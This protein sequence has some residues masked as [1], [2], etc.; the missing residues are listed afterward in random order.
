MTGMEVLLSKNV[1][2]TIVLAPLLGSI[3]AGL[4]G[5]FV[6]RAGAHTATILG[7]A[8]SCVLSCWVL[9]QLVAQGASPFNENLYTFFEV[10]NINGHVGFMIDKLTAMMMVVVTFVSLLVHVY[11][12]GY[13]AEDPGTSASSATSRCS[14]SAC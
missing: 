12:I 3:I 13:M 4:F 8:T 10:G 1:L 5:R 14:P 9:Y 11:T 2:L 7:V 6:G